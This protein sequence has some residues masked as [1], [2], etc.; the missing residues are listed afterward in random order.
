MSALWSLAERVM[1][2]VVRAYWRRYYDDGRCTLCGNRGVLDSRAV[3][4]PAGVPV[5]RL[6][7]CVCPN[8]QG[9]RRA[10]GRA[11]PTAEDWEWYRQEPTPE[12]LR[13]H[14]QEDEPG[15]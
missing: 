6:N 10:T 7:W 13:W 9:Q 4:T 11:V 14:L 1:S 5:G 8:G 2:A 15:A 12:S 3:C